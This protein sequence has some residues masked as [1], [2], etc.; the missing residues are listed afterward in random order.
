MADNQQK[1]DGQQKEKGKVNGEI[2]HIRVKED[3]NGPMRIMVPQPH[4]QEGIVDSNVDSEEEEDEVDFPAVEKEVDFPAVEE[5][6][7][8][9]HGGKE[10]NLLALIP[11][12]NANNVIVNVTI[13]DY[14]GNNYRE[15]REE[16]SNQV[17]NHA[18]LNLN[19]EV[20]RDFLGEERYIMELNAEF[21]LDQEEGANGPANSS[22][23]RHITQGGV[24]SRPSSTDDVGCVSP[25]KSFI[26]KTK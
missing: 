13:N 4:R 16:L 17:I 25:P 24:N 15:D 22:N 19:Q 3:S 6:A 18:N 11:C 23:F 5:E 9:E 20:V 8:R 26:D 1:E 2:F 14:E 10:E 21:S 7:E 12:L